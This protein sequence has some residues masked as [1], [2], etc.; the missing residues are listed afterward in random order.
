MQIL[1][2]FRVNNS[3]ELVIQHPSKLVSFSHLNKLISKA[4]SAVCEKPRFI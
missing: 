4:H 2:R 3:M 1:I